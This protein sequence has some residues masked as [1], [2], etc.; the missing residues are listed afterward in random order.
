MQNKYFLTEAFRNVKLL[1]PQPY[2]EMIYKQVSLLEKNAGFHLLCV[3]YWWLRSSAFIFKSE[4]V[5]ML[6][7]SE[8]SSFLCYLRNTCKPIRLDL[9]RVPRNLGCL[10]VIPVKKLLRNQVSWR[11]IVAFTQVTSEMIFISYN[12]LMHMWLL[13]FRVFA[14]RFR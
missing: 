7:G 4:Y 9:H 11:D 2:K 10:S 12:F 3:F 13:Y 6:N 14:L 5:S 1:M 8:M